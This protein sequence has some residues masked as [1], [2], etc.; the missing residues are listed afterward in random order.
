MLKRLC[1][2]SPRASLL[3]IMGTENILNAAAKARSET[4]E[5]LGKDAHAATALAV[6]LGQLCAEAGLSVA[7]VLAV[8]EVAHREAQLELDRGRSD[9][10]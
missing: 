2:R 3:R 9:A 1:S 5:R 4:R 6:A 7:D 8:T 10:A